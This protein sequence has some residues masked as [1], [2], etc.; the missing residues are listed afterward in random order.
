MMLSYTDDA[1]A[2]ASVPISRTGNDTSIIEI[3]MDDRDMCCDLHGKLR[4]GISL[5]DFFL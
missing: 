2:E 5:I 4:G 3:P 1:P